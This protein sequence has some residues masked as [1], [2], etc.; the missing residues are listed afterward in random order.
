MRKWFFPLFSTFSLLLSALLFTS[1]ASDSVNFSPY[2]ITSDV[3][4]RTLAQ[5]PASSTSLSSFSMSSY[6]STVSIGQ[7]YRFDIIN[8]P[9][10]YVITP[11]FIPSFSKSSSIISSS[12]SVSF[13][14]GTS[15]PGLYT[16]TPLYSGLGYYTATM[17]LSPAVLTSSFNF[18]GGEVYSYQVHGSYT[19]TITV[20]GQRSS[21][22][23]QYD[24]FIVDSVVPISSFSIDFDISP[25]QV[26]SSSS[27]GTISYSV[28]IDVSNLL[29]DVNKS[30]TSLLLTLPSGNYLN[31]SGA[32]VSGS[33]VPAYTYLTQGFL[34]I[35]NDLMGSTGSLTVTYRS[36]SST[37][38]SRT[39]T[40]SSVGQI[41]GQILESQSY[42]FTSFVGATTLNEDGTTGKLT[43][44]YGLTNIINSS[45]PGLAAVLRG[46]S[47]N[48]A[49]MSV[50]SSSDITHSTQFRANNLLDAIVGSIGVLQ[51]DLAM[52]RFTLASDQDIRMREDL[53]DQYD[54]IEDN[55]TSD[56]G[57]GKVNSD[58]I[59]DTAGMSGGIKNNFNSPSTVA[60][61]F[62]QLGSSDNFSY[63]SSAVAEELEPSN[64]VS[65]Y[66]R[67]DDGYRDLL[68]EKLDQIFNGGGSTW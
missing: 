24:S 34:G 21:Y 8:S 35:G 44:N 68:S 9:S 63:F 33:N 11:G 40:F 5:V 54:S 42:E 16:V 12:G 47:G 59:S 50:L 6:S 37:D 51:P 30:S 28:S 29:V 4:V 22:V 65:S 25:V 31:S 56:N 57:N 52:L 18:S 20:N 32:S 43:R 49:S 17:N 60:D 45:F 48:I 1:F 62:S 41:L 64:V 23:K 36:P 3:F 61:A 15:Q 46:S 19:V 67:F 14:T 38:S 10:T 13:D 39:I 55:F 58:Q 66:S 27:S 26:N 2:S 53:Q 7:V